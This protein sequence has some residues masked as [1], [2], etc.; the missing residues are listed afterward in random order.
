MTTLL[1]TSQSTGVEAY[2]DM[3][4]EIT[5]KLY[6][7]EATAHG[8]YP[9]NTQVAQLAPGAPSAPPDGGER[10]FT[11]LTQIGYDATTGT[12]QQPQQQPQ[13]QQ[14]QQH[15]QQSS[16]GTPAGDAFKAGEH[17]STA[18]GLAA[19]MQ[20]G[21]PPP[22]TILNPVNFPPGTSKTPTNISGPSSE[23]RW[24]GHHQQ[25]QGPSADE[26]QGP[27]HAGKHSASG[28]ATSAYRGKSYKKPKTERHGEGGS[29]GMAA[30]GGLN[31]PSTADRSKGGGSGGSTSGYSAT[32]AS[33]STTSATGGTGVTPVKRYTCSSCPY[34]TDRRDLF[35]RHENIHKEEKPFQCYACLKPFNRADH[36]KKHFLRMHREL[37]YDIAKTR[38]YPPGTSSSSASSAS[39]SAASGAAGSSG[40]KASS[41]YSSAANGGGGAGVHAAS[42]VTSTSGAASSSALAAM[43]LNIPSSGSYT[44][45]AGGAG[46]LHALDHHAM[47]NSGH[48]SHLLQLQQA[49]HQHQQ[50]QHHNVQTSPHALQSISVKQEKSSGLLNT[51]GS[52]VGSLGGEDKSPFPKKVKGEKKFSCAFCPW[53]G[54]DNWGLKR[55]LNTHTKPYVCLLCDYK[56]ARSERLATHVFKVHNRKACGKCNF[57]A[58]DQSQLDAHLHEAHPHEATKASNISNTNSNSGGKGG[59]AATPLAQHHPLHHPH[60]HHHQHHSQHLPP[61]SA[62]PPPP[63]SGVVPSSGSSSS[64]S[65]SNSSSS[66]AAVLRNLGNAFPSNNLPTNIPPTTGNGFGNGPSNGHYHA[67]NLHHAATGNVL[68][69]SNAANL[70]DTINQHLAATTAAG[71]QHQQQQQQQHHHNHHHHNRIAWRRRRGAE[72]LYSYLE[73]DGSDSGD[74]ARLLHMQAVGRNKASVTQDFHNAGGGDYNGINGHGS[75]SSSPSTKATAMDKQNGASTEGSDGGGVRIPAAAAAAAMADGSSAKLSSLASL[76]GGDQLSFLQLL[77]TAAVAQQHLQLQS[78]QHTKKQQQQ[79][80]QQQ[81]QPHLIQPKQP[82]A[83]NGSFSSPMASSPPATSTPHHSS[84]SSSNN[85]HNS[86]NG[87]TAQPLPLVKRRRATN[88]ELSNDKENLLYRKHHATGAATMASVIVNNTASLIANGV[89]IAATASLP[90]ITNGRNGVKNGHHHHHHHHNHHHNNNNNSSTNNKNINDIFDKVYKKPQNTFAKQQPTA[91]T[92][93]RTAPPSAIEEDGNGPPVATDY[94]DPAAQCGTEKFSL[95]EFLKNHTEVSISTVG[96]GGGAVP[97]GKDGKASRTAAAPPPLSSPSLDDEEGHDSSSC[98]G[99]SSS[100]SSTSS[101]KRK[102]DNGERNPRKQQQPRRIDEFE[103][104]EPVA[105]KA[106]SSQPSTPPPPAPAAAAPRPML[107]VLSPAEVVSKLEERKERDL[108]EQKE[109]EEE[110]KEEDKTVDAE[111]LEEVQ[112]DGKSKDDANA[113]AQSPSKLA[114]IRDK[115]MIQL[116]TRRLCCRICQHQGALEHLDNCHYH[117]KISLLL[118]THWRHQRTS[119]SRIRCRQCDSQF[120]RRYKLILHQKLT[121]HKGM[122]D[123]VNRKSVNGDTEQQDAITAGE[124]TCAGQAVLP[125]KQRKRKPRSQCFTRRRK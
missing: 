37:E 95:A 42:T 101:R 114:D 13:Q 86:T 16:G 89:T 22:G 2:E 56:A 11:T 120:P 39:S 41:Y 61:P 19:L 125:K 31:I 7:D 14:Q 3:F 23:D 44:S 6:G 20:G 87:V 35:T 104:V 53:A 123:E 121:G 97:T 30:T 18:F 119:G 70:I 106:A 34:T 109:E 24:A 75:P 71:T 93:L 82:S 47:L 107:K 58:D 21:F 32:G 115:H 74:Y 5:R 72:L 108:A 40:T 55:H 65:S 63:S 54:T 96:G 26:Q 122:I 51:S 84:I 29:P 77:A 113:Q 98:S 112:Q 43:P 81:Q 4:K 100:S 45:G 33:T 78:G 50:Q 79:Q 124:G 110:E 28:P 73:A 12:G 36:V 111:P 92:I 48:T 66:N 15:P 85:T 99:S 117:S 25:Q 116:V 57:I 118:H 69:N 60:H 83:T 64:S 88:N 49:H 52:S 59:G 94:T 46:G 90:A 1:P 103:T 91:V 102:A 10:S 62:L 27:W 67:T 17:I 68:T 76:L 38:R 8:L 80:Q 9:H 105:A